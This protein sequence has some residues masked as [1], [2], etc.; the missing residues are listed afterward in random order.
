M[1]FYT[2]EQSLKDAF[3]DHEAAGLLAD[4]PGTTSAARLE[5]ASKTAY[6][7]INS[8]LRA[9]G[10]VTPPIFTPYRV[11]IPA[12]GVAIPLDGKI[13][14]ISD[15]FT[16]YY[17]AAT[18]D[19]NKKVYTDRRAQGLDF[20]VALRDGDVTLGIALTERLSGAGDTVVL[21][22]PQVMDLVVMPQSQVAK[23]RYPRQ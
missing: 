2:N 5:K 15:V 16:A 11:D 14:E 7:E 10:Y 17:L 13:Q 9:G 22:R 3:G 23:L 4:V 21:S 6:D 8:Y 20:L 12:P 19:M 18:E 1:D